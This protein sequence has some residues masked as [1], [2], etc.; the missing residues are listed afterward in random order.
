MKITNEQ[1]GKVAAA[2]SQGI[3][4]RLA[5]RPGAQT[6]GVPITVDVIKS[7]AFDAFEEACESEFD[8]DGEPVEISPRA[9]AILWE[10]ILKINS[11]ALDSVYTSMEKAKTL[12]FKRAA[13]TRSVK[14][15]SLQYMK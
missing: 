13:S 10:G 6:E 12:P 1:M 7:V 5:K 2:F 11:S 15:L 4:D 9:A 8:A 3:I 14:G